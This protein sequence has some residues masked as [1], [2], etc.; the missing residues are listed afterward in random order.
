LGILVGSRAS[1]FQHRWRRK[2]R[3]DVDAPFLPV[4]YA[5]I[6]L[7]LCIVGVA[8]SNSTTLFL[9][10][11]LGAM[12][13]FFSVLSP[14]SLTL[15]FPS[16]RWCAAVVAFPSAVFALLRAIEHSP[17]YPTLLGTMVAPDTENSSRPKQS[18]AGRPA[19]ADDRDVASPSFPQIIRVDLQR[20]VRVE[21]LEDKSERYELQERSLDKED[22]EGF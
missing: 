8:R 5:S 18:V 13:V 15:F 10:F 6:S 22:S 14:S 19:T 3:G 17:R 12:R 21:T 1:L 16:R 9:F 20:E 2:E 11:E 7:T 4:V